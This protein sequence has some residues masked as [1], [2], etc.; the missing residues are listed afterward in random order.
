MATRSAARR[1]AQVLCPEIGTLSVDERDAVKAL[2]LHLLQRFDQERFEPLDSDGR[3]FLTVSHMQRL[4]LHVG[5][6]RKGEKAA[7]EAIRWL[8]TSGILE[9]TGEVKLPRRKPQRMAAREKFGRRDVHV[10]NEGGRDAQPSLARSFWWRVFRVVPLSAVLRAYGAMRG[11]YAQVPDLPQRLA[12]LSA[13]AE[14]QGLISR[15]RG[16]RGARKGS[17]QWVFA[18][19]GPP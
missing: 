7:A 1:L 15:S 11:A 10:R 3:T 14:R 18:N 4:L 12:S 8:C 17:V 5:A 16:R 2:G 13:F 19:S 6:R 9:D